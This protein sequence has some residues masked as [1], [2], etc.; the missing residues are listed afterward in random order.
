[1]VRYYLLCT[2]SLCVEDRT[3][4]YGFVSV[5]CLSWIEAKVFFC[6][7]VSGMAYSQTHT[8]ITPL[9]LPGCSGSW[10]ITPVT[11]TR[12]HQRAPFT[13]LPPPSTV[14]VDLCFWYVYNQ[15][16]YFPTKCPLHHHQTPQPER[17][18]PTAPI[19]SIQIYTRAYSV[20]I[21]TEKHNIVLVFIFIFY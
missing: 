17:K 7:F 1:M 18:N 12:V 8:D 14:N 21:E 16:Y 15:S 6:C 11:L 5:S 4:M 2:V 19:L 13:K 10:S 3:C 9:F 20:S